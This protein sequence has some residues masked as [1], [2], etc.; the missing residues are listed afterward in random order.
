MTLTEKKGGTRILDRD[1]KEFSD[2]IDTMEMVDIRTNNGQ[3]S[4][5]NK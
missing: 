4:W 3:F 5:N 2:F 1:A